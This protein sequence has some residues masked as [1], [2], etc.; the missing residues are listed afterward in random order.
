MDE[1]QPVPSWFDDPNEVAPCPCG[2]PLDEDCIL[3]EGDVPLKRWFHL[4]H[5]EFLEKEMDDEEIEEKREWERKMM[6]E[7]DDE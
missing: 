4:E 7:D 3:I 2:E 5:L 1:P 6:G